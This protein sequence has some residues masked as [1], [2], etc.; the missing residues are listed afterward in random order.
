MAIDRP[1][2]WISVA[3]PMTTS[4]AAAIITSRAPVRAMTWNS[5]VSR[6]RPASTVTETAATAMAKLCS[7][8]PL[9]S[10]PPSRMV[11]SARSGTIARSWNSR[12]QKDNCP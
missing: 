11:I 7:G 9:L 2:A 6:K 3:K 4:R 12:M 5:G 1:A 8:E 10:T